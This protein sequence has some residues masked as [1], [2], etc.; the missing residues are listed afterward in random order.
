[1]AS[2]NPEWLDRALEEAQGLSLS[3]MVKTVSYLLS[4]GDKVALKIALLADEDDLDPK[5]LKEHAMSIKYLTQALQGY[6][7]VY[8]WCEHASVQVRDTQNA[9]QELVRHL[10]STELRQLQGWLGRVPPRHVPS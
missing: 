9:L 7:S 1:V 4:A 5:V 8:A 6:V 10:D 3:G 2:H